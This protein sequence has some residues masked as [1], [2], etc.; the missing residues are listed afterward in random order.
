[1]QHLRNNIWWKRIWKIIYIYMFV[2]LNHSAIWKPTP[3]FLLAWRIPR[4]EEP[5]GRQSIGSPGVRQDWSDLHTHTC[6]FV[7]M[8]H[9]TVHLKRCKST[10]LQFKKSQ[11]YCQFSSVQSLSRVRL[12]ATPWIA[13][14][15]ASLSIT[16]SQSSLRLTSIESVMPS[17]H[18]ILCLCFGYQG[19]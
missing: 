16:N 3:V 13:A 10:V 9:F 1:M 5:G 7:S 11:K 8:N 18:L 4:T 17:S 12:F 2:S 15:Q 14:H 6:M 19:K